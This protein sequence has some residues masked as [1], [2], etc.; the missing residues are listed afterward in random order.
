MHLLPAR[1][2]GDPSG[3][4]CGGVNSNL[5]ASTSYCYSAAAAAASIHEIDR[6]KTME[7]SNVYTKEKKKNDLTARPERKRER[8]KEREKE[9]E[10]LNYRVLSMRGLQIQG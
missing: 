9:R 8:Q 2:S 3:R 10:R 6:A 4:P 1:P 5:Y 7:F